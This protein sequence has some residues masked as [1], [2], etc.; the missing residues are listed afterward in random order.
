MHAFRKVVGPLYYSFV[1]IFFLKKIFF[2]YEAFEHPFRT[3]FM[4]LI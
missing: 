2:F 4:A 1:K 3:L